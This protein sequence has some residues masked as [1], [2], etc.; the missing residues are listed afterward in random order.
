MFV[1]AVVSLA[2]MVIAGALWMFGPRANGDYDEASLRWAARG[3]F[4]LLAFTSLAL[5]AMAS[6]SQVPQRNVGIVTEFGKAT[7]RETGPG[8]KFTAPWQNVEDW[9]ASNQAYDHRGD[10]ACVNVRIATL[11]NACVEVLIE[12]KTKPEQASEQWAAYK[13]DF[14]LFVGRRVD[15]AITLS[16]NDAFAAYNPLA[17]VD[18]NTGNLNV[19]TGPLAEQVEVALTGRLGGDIEILSVIVTRVN[20]DEKTQQAID[21]YQASIAKARVLEQDKKNADLQKQ[22][23][24]TNAQSDPVTRCL[25]LADKHGKEPGFCLGGGN[26]VQQR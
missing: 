20:H 10:K 7:G 14:E 18:A 4:F 1:A 11:A 26:P 22:V 16:L 24:E 25:E 9:D 6:V 8:L 19:P 3:T 5:L 2:L 21:A 15:P 12:W 17:N 13:R 23:T